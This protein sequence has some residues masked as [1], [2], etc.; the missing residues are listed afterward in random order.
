MVYGIGYGFGIS[1]III[2]SFYIGFER[3]HIFDQPSNFNW[4]HRLIPPTA[5]AI[6][7]GTICTVS[8]I[9]VRFS[10]HSYARPLFIFYL[11]ILIYGIIFL[12]I[13]LRKRDCKISDLLILIQIS[14]LSLTTAITSYVTY[15]ILGSDFFVHRG[16]ISTIIT[17]GTISTL[18][19][20]YSTYPLFHVLGAMLNLLTLADLQTNIAIITWIPYIITLWALFLIFKQVI[21]N[22]G[23]LLAS[24][25]LVG[26]KYFLFWGAYPVP[27]TMIIGFFTIFVLFMLKK[28]G[29]HKLSAAITALILLLFI[30]FMHPLGVCAFALSIVG[31]IG[32]DALSKFLYYKRAP[33]IIRGRYA[34]L[35]LKIAKNC[36]QNFSFYLVIALVLLIVAISNW[37][38][39]GEI[40]QY[41]VDELSRNL[42]T[43]SSKGLLSSTSYKPS[44]LYELENINVY[45]LYIIAGLGILYL[46]KNL[47]KTTFKNSNTILAIMSISFC[48]LGIGHIFWFTGIQF[49]PHRWI[50][51]GAVLICGFGAYFITLTTGRFQYRG[52]LFCLALI[53]LVFTV[54][55]FNSEYN[56][57]NPQ[58]S[59]N[60]TVYN[61]RQSEWEAMQFSLQTIPT[62]GNY[63][64]SMEA[65]DKKYP[66]YTQKPENLDPTRISTYYWRGN[67]ISID[68][69]HLLI[70]EIYY[71]RPL[72]HSK[73]LPRDL[74]I[75]LESEP[76]INAV[77][78]NNQASLYHR[79]NL[80]M[81]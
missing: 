1:L 28:P 62:K 54:G 72:I 50:L 23:A 34:T 47:L 67:E 13:V 11:M 75:I 53:L 31:M 61:L 6:I 65:Q 30:T 33:E 69:T 18:G 35:P 46:I 14:V 17:D 43:T 71:E 19:G 60:V 76:D 27:F 56:V 8:V 24:M 78:E 21:G 4:N 81:L 79:G 49:V 70:R 12:Q 52:V 15:D 26:N 32:L 36:Q 64:L 29:T 20:A 59:K 22:T 25:L 38:Y 68:T 9:L 7:T 3:H 45:I 2:G 48:F 57:D 42:S 73:P 16:L 55:I 80:E 74:R 66:L 10:E 58:L 41:I 5:I 51:L 63:G 77:Y 39:N 44:T 40:F 37:I